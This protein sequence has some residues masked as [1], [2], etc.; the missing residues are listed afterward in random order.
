M[1]IVHVAVA[2]IA[3]KQGRILL[4]KRPEAAHQGGLWEFP[5]GK[6]D[7]GEDLAGAL[8]R[9]CRE[10]LG[11]AVRGHRPLIRVEHRYPDRQV[12]LDVHRVIAYDGEP[13]GM[14]GQPLA[15]ARPAE[16]DDYPMPA[17]DRPIVNA[18]R[19]PDR[20][21]IT[22][23]RVDDRFL[24]MD[25]LHGSLERGARLIQF[26]VKSC[27]DPRQR[28]AEDALQLCSR[29]GAQMLIN[30]D[31]DL[32][33]TIGAAGVHLKSAQLHEL[34]ARP[35]GLDWVGA[36]CHELRDLERLTAL[37]VDFAVLSPVKPTT[38]HAETPPLGWP[39]FGAL[40]QQAGVPV[41]AL[42]GL[43]PADLH[44]AWRAG[45]QGIAAIT[46]LWGGKSG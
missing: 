41:F 27:S 31:I 38:S 46:G 14:E 11:I 26:R 35:E 22:P 6:L 24:F 1:D 44:D 8:R 2:V 18:I 25:Q 36:S 13:Q 21:V 5:G 42:G 28:L 7:P 19:L 37:D 4:A 32:A 20:Y 39:A 16:L 40:A 12:L 45:A 23:A 43:G 9:E 30:E 29:S 34:T 17:A 33:R 10:E 15:W 3:D